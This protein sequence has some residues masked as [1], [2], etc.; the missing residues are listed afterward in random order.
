[1]DKI[2]QLSHW[3]ADANRIVFFGGAGC[4][5]ESG[6]P[7]FRS[8]NGL[9]SKHY[10]QLSAETILSHSFFQ[11]EPEL[12]Y[13]FYRKYLY[14]PNAVP[15]RAHKI[16]AKLEE[17]GKLLGIVTQNI[18]NLHQEAGS[19]NVKELHGSLSRNYCSTCK[20]PYDTED[21]ISLEGV[22]RCECG[23]IIRPDIVLYEESLDSMVIE[24]S[25]QMI[26]DADVLIVGGTSLAV[27]PANSFIRYYRGNQLALINLSST[28]FDYKADLVIHEKLGDVLEQAY[29]GA[30]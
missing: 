22:P 20:V 27:S 26:Y 5:T 16:L 7:D 4:S 15:N 30:L 23:G 18:D 25:L 19:K 29:E 3:I 11:K 24:E 1:M 21:I 12:F 17:Q 2:K 9:Y 10:G 13:D 28:P 8:G 6:I 14:F